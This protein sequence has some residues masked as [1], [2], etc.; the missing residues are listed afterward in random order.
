MPLRRRWWEVGSRGGLRAA[1]G[2]AEAGGEGGE[3]GGV[4]V[5]GWRVAA[6]EL[7]D[8]MPHGLGR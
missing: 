1:A 4:G 7:F 5:R 8:G 6:H 2:C 3:A